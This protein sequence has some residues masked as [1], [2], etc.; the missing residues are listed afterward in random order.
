MDATRCISYL[1][2]ENRG[3]IPREL[4]ALI[5]NRI[6]GCDICQ[7]VCP[8]NRAPVPPHPAFAPRDEYRST[9]V[10]DLLRF[11][12]ADFSNLFRKS[13]IK[14]AKLAGMQRNVAALTDAD[15]RGILKA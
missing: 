12:Q 4:R 13:P 10:T 14:R 1:T 2:I 15:G 11:A 3:P 7:E 5:G 8:W 6:F 9:P